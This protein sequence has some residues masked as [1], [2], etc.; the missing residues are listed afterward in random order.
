MKLSEIKVMVEAEEKEEVRLCKKLIEKT[1]AC[2]PGCSAKDVKAGGT[3]P[4]S[5]KAQ[6][7]CPCFA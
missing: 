4:F 3:C 5:E 6:H 2:K 1:W 7:T